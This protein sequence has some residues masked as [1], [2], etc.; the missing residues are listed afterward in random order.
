MRE[1]TD[2]I[3]LQAAGAGADLKDLNLLANA[4]WEQWK[5]QHPDPD[6]DPDGFDDRY[7]RLGTTMDGAGR[8]TG[9]LIHLSDTGAQAL[10]D[11]IDLTLLRSRRRGRDGR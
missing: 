1:E 11:A 4:A 10:A 8:L 9:N 7:L 2:Q 6:D 3:L 5:S